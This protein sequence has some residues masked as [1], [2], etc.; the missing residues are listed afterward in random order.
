MATFKVHTPW[1]NLLN[2]AEECQGYWMLPLPRGP[3][4]GWCFEPAEERTFTIR[5]KSAPDSLLLPVSFL[6]QW[7]CASFLVTLYPLFSILNHWCST[8]GVLQRSLRSLKSIPALGLLPG[9][10]NSVV[11]VGDPGHVHLFFKTS[12]GNSD[13]HTSWEMFSRVSPR[14][15]GEYERFWTRSWEASNGIHWP[16]NQLTMQRN[17]IWSLSTIEMKVGKNKNVFPWLISIEEPRDWLWAWMEAT[18]W[19]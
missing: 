19:S 13:F 6:M 1:S 4:P 8:N 18:S 2:I 7:S 5:R 11:V 17:I 3:E 14:K 15:H 10:S 16:R 12:L 9:G